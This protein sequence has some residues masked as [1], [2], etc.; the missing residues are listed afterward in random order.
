[1]RKEYVVGIM[2]SI[3]EKLVLLINKNRPDWQVGM[4]NGIGGK[5]ER[6]ESPVKAMCREF[7]KE[8]GIFTEQR[9]WH[10]FLT[11]TDDYGDNAEPYVV[12]FFSMHGDVYSAQKVT[13]EEPVVVSVN[14]VMDMHTIVPNLKWII[15][16]A[17][18]SQVNTSIVYTK[19]ANR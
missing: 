19:Y 7:M 18:D 8:S 15:P 4:V 16:L 2:F 9:E 10:H 6:G 13:D 5:I 17:M 11:L 14:R 3:D 1:M 12:H